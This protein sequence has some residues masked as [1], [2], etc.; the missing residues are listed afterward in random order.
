MKD[1]TK[2][3]L[4][5]HKE[6]RRQNPT[7]SEDIQ[8]H[9]RLLQQ[10]QKE[11]D[12]IHDIFFKYSA[13]QRINIIKQDREIEFQKRFRVSPGGNF[14]GSSKRISAVTMAKIQQKQQLQALI[15]VNE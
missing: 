9:S 10:R 8:L 2:I 6:S 11:S 3:A 12:A 15:K 13:Q 7:R 14:S 4:Q 1:V 5:L